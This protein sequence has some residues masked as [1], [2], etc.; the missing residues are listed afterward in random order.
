M[1]IAQS[2]SRPLRPSH[3]IRQTLIHIVLACML[4]A[5]IGIAVLALGM[6]QVLGERVSQG[7][8]MTAHT[9]MRAVDRDLVA[10]QTALEVL[11]NSPTLATDDL[12]AFHQRALDVKSKFH[13]S[14]IILADRSGQQLVN[15]RTRFG[16]TLPVSK[17]AAANDTVFRT[18]KPFIADLFRETARSVVSIKVPVFRD[19]EVKYVLSINLALESLNELLGR[20]KL[21]TDWQAAIFDASGITIATTLDQKYV[22]RMGPPDLLAAMAREGAGSVMTKS[23]DGLPVY[24]AF[25]RSEISNWSVAIGAP[26]T[27][28]TDPLFV[29]LSLS[30][31]GAVVLL[32]GGTALAGYQSRKIATAVQSLVRS[33]MA[34]GDAERSPVPPSRIREIDEV[35]R[36]LDA[37]MQALQ[38][39]TAERDRAERDKEVAEET[40]RVKDEFIATVSH[41]LR[42]PLT[43]IAASLALIE[44]APDAN[45]SGET[46]EL[47]GIAHANSRRLHRLVNDILDIEK[48]EAGKVAFHVQRI[49]VSALLAQTIATNRTLAQSQGVHLRFHR[50]AVHNILA[51]PDRLTQVISNLLSNAVK[52]SPRGADIVIKAEDHAGK[53]RIS[54]RDHG[55]GIPE[56]F[57]AHIFEKFCQA[58]SPDARAKGTGLGLSI[59]KGFVEH[60]GGSVGF[61]EAP[62][63][64]AVFYVDLPQLEGTDTSDAPIP[65]RARN[66]APGI[67]QAA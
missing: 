60:M 36:G 39:R 27:L 64:G 15:T 24:G 29:F 38:H 9:L 25:G 1:S 31:A 13:S 22:G 48:L 6:Y 67:R 19:G 50:T 42:T 16:T 59:V 46:E 65:L 11:A 57:K 8:I 44:D 66:S 43:A 26:T 61:A 35:G 51:D 14:S 53:V 18:G 32:L 12:A 23:P 55:P 52:F 7:A 10:A 4:P 62:G 30:A 56:Q 21:P 34:F 40:A 58:D 63:G 47:I 28:V 5:W 2:V 20:Q 54:V 41:E 17:S 33:A 37:A 49:E 45:L 3:T